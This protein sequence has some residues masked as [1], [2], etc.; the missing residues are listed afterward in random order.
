MAEVSPFE[1]QV[2]AAVTAALAPAMSRLEAVLQNAREINGD[3]EGIRQR[4]D[5]LEA[6]GSDWFGILAERLGKVDARLQSIDARVSTQAHV[7][8]VLARVNDVAAMLETATELGQLPALADRL[9]AIE[10]ALEAGVSL[11]QLRAELEARPP[12]TG[13]ASVDLGPVLS[14][15]GVILDEVRTVD[16]GVG[17]IEREMERVRQAVEAL[18]A[19]GPLEGPV[20]VQI[21]GE[22]KRGT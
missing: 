11:Q 2:T 10:A 17:G 18:P 20:I 12:V 14:R 7:V 13:G 21:V 8:A 3:V 4:L 9:E 22:F 19:G 16:T 5:A 15:L 1:A 6:Q